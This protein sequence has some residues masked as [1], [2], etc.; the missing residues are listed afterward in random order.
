[1][2]KGRVAEM[3]NLLKKYPQLMLKLTVSSM[4]LILA[5]AKLQ[6]YHSSLAQEIKNDIGYVNNMI[7]AY[8]DSS[9]E[10]EIFAEKFM[11]V[12]SEVDKLMAELI[13]K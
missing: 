10:D 6:A 2:T 4:G 5:T 13:P 12:S 11:Q 8:I 3:A 1:M 7:S 9:N